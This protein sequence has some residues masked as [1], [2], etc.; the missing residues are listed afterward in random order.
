MKLEQL[1]KVH[2][3]SLVTLISSWAIV[4]LGQLAHRGTHEGE[5]K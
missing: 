3:D 1:E 4:G 2:F 5:S